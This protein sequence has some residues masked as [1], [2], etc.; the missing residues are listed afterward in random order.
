MNENKTLITDYLRAMSGRSKPA[1]L[2]QKYV[3]DPSLAAHIAETE[4]AFPNYEIAVEDA[5]A[6]GDLVSVR[7]KFRGV[8][9]GLFAGIAATGATVSAG[10]IIIYRVADGRIVEHWMQ[11]D[12]M[13]LLEQLQD[14]IVGTRA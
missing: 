2:V 1:G 5:I 14:A 4:A 6:E 9:G 8:H 13:A 11:F 3:A 7:A 12:R 10:L